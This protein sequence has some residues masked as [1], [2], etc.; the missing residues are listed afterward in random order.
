MNVC[1]IVLLH[2]FLNEHERS[3]DGIRVCRGESIRGPKTNCVATPGTLPVSLVEIAIVSDQ[4]DLGVSSSVLWTSETIH[5]RSYTCCSLQHMFKWLPKMISYLRRCRLL[6]TIKVD[7]FNRGHFTGLVGVHLLGGYLWN[8]H[9]CRK[10][11]LGFWNISENKNSGHYQTRYCQNIFLLLLKLWLLGRAKAKPLYT[12][13][14][15]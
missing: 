13:K 14:F 8:L 1:H 4:S 12:G 5:R 9:C 6:M 10:M 3:Q 15:S 7:Y 2:E 11:T